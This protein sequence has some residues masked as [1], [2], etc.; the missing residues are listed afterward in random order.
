MS[1]IPLVD[2][3]YQNLYLLEYLWCEIIMS[4]HMN[5]MLDLLEITWV[6]I[7]KVSIDGHN[8]TLFVN[9]KK[10]KK[11]KTRKCLMQCH[12]VHLLCRS[13]LKRPPWYMQTTPDGACECPII[14]KPPTS[15]RTGK[16]H[17]FLTVAMS[18]E[19]G[20]LF[21]YKEVVFSCI[22]KSH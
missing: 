12:T 17:C 1:S 3:L 4:F 7:S 15:L 18:V 20:T 2:I 8:W 9:S 13:G 16:W 19:P 22:P 6:F 21:Q 14:V 10:K 11:K 5:F